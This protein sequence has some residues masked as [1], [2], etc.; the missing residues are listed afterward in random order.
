MC[1]GEASLLLKRVML[2]SL[3][4]RGPWPHPTRFFPNMMHSSCVSTVL[5]S[6]KTNFQ[7]R[8]SLLLFN[9]L[10]GHSCGAGH[11]IIHWTKLH[12]NLLSFSALWWSET[13]CKS[14]RENSRSNHIEEKPVLS[15]VLPLGGKPDRAK[16]WPA[17]ALKPGC[18]GSNPGSGDSLCVCSFLFCKLWITAGPTLQG[19]WE[20]SLS[21][22]IWST[23]N[24]AL[25]YISCHHLF[26][27]Q[28]ATLSL[29]PPRQLTPPASQLTA[30]PWE[31]N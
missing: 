23:E 9:S 15:S 1:H 22:H 19:C 10:E 5:Q 13:E 17:L 25:Y 27:P 3:L 7:R 12:Q 2:A 11:R 24:S 16:K 18:R 21:E 29:W 28:P 4:S 8:Q 14:D 6:Y 31:R 26:C 30:E 20:D